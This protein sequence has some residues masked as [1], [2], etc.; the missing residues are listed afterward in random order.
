MKRPILTLFLPGGGDF[1]PPST[2]RQFSPDVLIR[3]G[4]KY[5]HVWSSDRHSKA[6]NPC[7][8][9]SETADPVHITNN[10]PTV[11][12]TPHSTNSHVDHA[13]H[14]LVESPANEID[15]VSEFEFSPTFQRPADSPRLHLN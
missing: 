4:S 13:K 8:Q 11:R 2:F 5:T 1:T 7:D 9:Y 12:S 6:S 14:S 10:E 15:E 3:G